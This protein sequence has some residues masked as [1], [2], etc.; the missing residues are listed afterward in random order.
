MEN[1][2]KTENKN[3][4]YEYKPNV[5]LLAGWLKNILIAMIFVNS[6]KKKRKLYKIIL[7]KAEKNLVAI[8]PNRSYTR[9]AYTSRRNK[10]STNIRYNM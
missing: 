3:L 6:K 5:N 8:N 7:E 2:E 1:P 10:Y 4:K 9:K